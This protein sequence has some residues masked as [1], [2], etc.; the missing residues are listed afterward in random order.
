L[1]STK[2]FLTR[3]PIG[4]IRTRAW[5]SFRSKICWTGRHRSHDSAARDWRSIAAKPRPIRSYDK[6]NFNVATQ[7]GND[8]Y[9]RTD[10]VAGNA[11][12]AK[13]ITRRSKDAGGPYQADAPHVVLARPR[14]K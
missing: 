10:P 1:T 5:D 3:N 7:T 14:K 4:G 11:G 8:V 13:I 6:F 12:E 2:I 9:S